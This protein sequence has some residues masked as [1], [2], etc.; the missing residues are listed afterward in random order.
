[1][2]LPVPGYTRISKI[3]GDKKADPP[4]DGLFPMSKP[5]WYR[6]VKAGRYPKVYKIGPNMS[7]CSNADLNGLMDRIDQGEVAA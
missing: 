4:I 1:M 7:A 3:I 2:K 5:S 6:G